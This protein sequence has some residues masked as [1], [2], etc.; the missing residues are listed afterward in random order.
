ML[1]KAN[2]RKALNVKPQQTYKM[3]A[4]ALSIFT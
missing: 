4:E 2:R 1:K 3:I